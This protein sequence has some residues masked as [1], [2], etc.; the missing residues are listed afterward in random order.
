MFKEAFKCLKP[1]GYLESHEPSSGFENEGEPLD[2]KSA[3]SQ[4]GR[5]FVKGGLKFGRSFTVFEDELQR[6]AME[7]AGFVD[8][9]VKDIKVNNI[10]TPQFDALASG[11]VLLLLTEAK[12]T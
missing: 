4:W 2:N 6:K 8:I 10:P 3:L 1:G 11:Q 9:E 7:E 12:R 5:F